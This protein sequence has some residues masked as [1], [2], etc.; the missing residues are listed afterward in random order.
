M[1]MAV[2]DPRRDELSGRVDDLRTAPRGEVLSDPRDL[3]I[4]D[5]DVRVL[6]RSFDRRQNSRVLDENLVA[7]LSKSRRCC[8][9]KNEGNQSKLKY[10][11]NNSIHHSPFTVHYGLRTPLKGTV[12]C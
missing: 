10:V 7:G 1:R 12:P 3:A 5:Q 6:E 2:D 9:R 11:H 8:D 4:A